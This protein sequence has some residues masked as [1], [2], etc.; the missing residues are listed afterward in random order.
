[1]G[2]PLF[3]VTPQ[4]WRVQINTANTN[5]D[6]SGTLLSLA[7]GNTAPGSRIDKIRIQGVG[8]V[9]DGMI[10]FFLANSS[11]ST[12]HLIKE[13]PVK[14]TVPSGTVA[15]FEDE[16]TMQEG[17][18]LPDATWSLLVATHVA[19]TFNIFGYGGNLG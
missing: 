16:W 11:G 10:R 3:I 8:S 12:K 2:Q 14:A 4:V 6:G 19:N 18:S 13:R 1:M 9:A 15:G 5:L 17:L 7:S